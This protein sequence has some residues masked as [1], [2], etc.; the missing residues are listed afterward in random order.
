MRRAERSPV[1]ECENEVGDI[2]STVARCNVAFY[3]PLISWPR[4]L[5]HPPPT[6]CSPLTALEAENSG[7]FVLINRVLHSCGWFHRQSYT[8]SLPPIRNT[9]WREEKWRYIINIFSL[10]MIFKAEQSEMKSSSS[11]L[12]LHSVLGLIVFWEILSELSSGERRRTKPCK[13]QLVPRQCHN[14]ATD[15]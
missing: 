3:P 12:R 13:F 6:H 14:S 4:S 11:L 15:R 1:M 2:S 10:L 9:E 5:S 7:L 8:P